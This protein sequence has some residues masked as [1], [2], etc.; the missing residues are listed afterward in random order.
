[1]H[2]Q[3]NTDHIQTTHIGSLPRPHK[4]LDMLKAKFAGE[5]YDA[6]ALEA[7]AAGARCAS[8]GT[9]TCGRCGTG[10]GTE[11][12]VVTGWEGAPVAGSRCE[13]R[14]GPCGLGR[15]VCRERHDA[16]ERDYREVDRAGGAMVDAGGSRDEVEV[17]RAANREA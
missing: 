11:G 15:T 16:H 12:A 10:A 2:I 4:L 3:Q 9:G 14:R 1:M 5:A 7:T 17:D 6:A 8:I 13:R